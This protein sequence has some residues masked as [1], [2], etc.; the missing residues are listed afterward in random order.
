M[1]WPYLALQMAPLCLSMGMCWVSWLDDTLEGQVLN[2]GVGGW[3]FT[4]CIFYI[5]YV[6]DAFAKFVS[7]SL[8]TDKILLGDVAILSRCRT[9]LSLPPPPDRFMSSEL[10]QSGTV[11]PW[12]PPFLPA[13]Q[14]PRNS[15]WRISPSFGGSLGEGSK[16]ERTVK[17]VC[18]W[19]LLLFP[20]VLRPT[21]GRGTRR[22]QPW[23]TQLAF[24][25]L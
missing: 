25:W 11:I 8:P 2:P 3:G 4:R 20:A 15:K 9:F 10:H 12:D 17:L 18:P 22:P 1:G 24:I 21:S 6:P 13:A 14:Q 5:C 19:S 23:K 7:A 16:S